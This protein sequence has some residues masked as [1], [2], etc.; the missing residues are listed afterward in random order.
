MYRLFFL[1]LCSA[2]SWAGVYY[3]N[4]TWTLGSIIMYYIIGGFCIDYAKTDVYK[5]YSSLFKDYGISSSDNVNVRFSF[6][7]FLALLVGF[8]I[9][10]LLFALFKGSLISFILSLVPWALGLEMATWPH[11]KI[12]AYIGR[13]KFLGFNWSQWFEEYLELSTPGLRST[14]NSSDKEREE[15]AQA[16]VEGLSQYPGCGI[17]LHGERKDDFGNSFYLGTELIKY[18]KAEAEK[19][20]NR[21]FDLFGDGQI[22]CSLYTSKG[23]LIETF[24]YSNHTPPE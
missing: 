21:F 12:E 7:D 17:E 1:P 24:K 2:L 15:C 14:S 5:R 10:Q 9:G 11:K 4:I 22:E 18:E 6:R 8:S 13:E 3:H 19:R 16:F 20:I 23:E